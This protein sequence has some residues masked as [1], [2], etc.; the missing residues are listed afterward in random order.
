MKFIEAVKAAKEGQ[1][2]RRKSWELFSR[3]TKILRRK[4]GIETYK[5]CIS[6]H[7][8]DYHFLF[9]IEDLEADN[10]VIKDRYL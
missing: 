10:W 5:A 4:G 2:I 8:G 6:S 3:D 7:D 1:E 9:T